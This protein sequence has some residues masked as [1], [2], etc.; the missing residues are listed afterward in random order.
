MRLTGGSC[1]TPPLSSPV[2]RRLA[3]VH[4]PRASPPAIPSGARM[5]LS[6]TDLILAATDLSGFLACPHLTTQSQAAALGG[7]KPPRFP[8]PAADVIRARG[9][10]HEARVLARFRAEGLR[11]VEIP[12]GAPVDPAADPAAHSTADPAADPAAHPPLPP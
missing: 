5:H 2:D 1:H 4:E 3:P 10:E 12:D 8:D 11:I 9:H 7:P 6:G